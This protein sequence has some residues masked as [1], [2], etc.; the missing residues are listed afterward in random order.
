MPWVAKSLLQN[1]LKSSVTV[2]LN[3]LRRLHCVLT[4]F[5]VH[6][7][8]L[9]MYKRPTC[10][11]LQVTQV[12]YDDTQVTVMLPSG[13]TITGTKA[14]IT[15]PLALLKQRAVF[16]EPPLPPKKIKAIEGLG[17]GYY[18]KGLLEITFKY[19]ETPLER[20]PF[21]CF[22]AILQL[23]YGFLHR[24]HVY[25]KATRWTFSD[26]NELYELKYALDT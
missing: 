12:Q 19:S 22:T 5:T 21:S 8:N 13:E 24:F 3:L 1:W 26:L 17:A 25:V 16:F 23:N 2:H 11:I 14:I 6:V 7:R 20:P 9:H 18:W 15:L 10:I 4:S